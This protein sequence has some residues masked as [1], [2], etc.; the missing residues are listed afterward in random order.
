M[1]KRGF[2]AQKNKPYKKDKNIKY[3]TFYYTPDI[4]ILFLH[5]LF[6]ILSCIP[7]H[8][9]HNSNPILSFKL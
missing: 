2:I 4:N 3:K 7:N 9:M 1:Y 8:I 5:L 6:N